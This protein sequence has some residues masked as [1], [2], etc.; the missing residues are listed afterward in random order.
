MQ[1]LR[2]PLEAP[3]APGGRRKKIAMFWATQKGSV[4][5]MDLQAKRWGVGA[6]PG[7]AWEKAK[8]SHE[9]ARFHSPA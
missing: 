7:K 5:V 3:G 8:V 9:Y 1:G 6:I 2:L 4:S